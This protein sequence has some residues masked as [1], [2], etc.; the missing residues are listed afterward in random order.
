MEV[1]EY[2]GLNCDPSKLPVFGDGA[3]KGIIKVK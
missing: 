3:F 2:Y 1:R